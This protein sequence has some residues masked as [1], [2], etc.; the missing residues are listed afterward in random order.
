MRSTARSLG[1]V[2]DLL[3]VAAPEL[4]AARLVSLC[5]I[6]IGLLLQEKATPG[7]P[8]AD[9]WTLF[10]GYPFAQK[11]GAVDATG[12]RT[13]RTARHTLWTWGR[14]LAWHEALTEY[15]RLDRQ[16]R[17]YEIADPA[18]PAVRRPSLSVAPDR[19]DAYERLLDVAP[20]FAG[21][22]MAFATAGRHAFPVGRHLATVQL[23]PCALP[24]PSGHDLAAPAVNGG[25]QLSFRWDK[26]LRTAAFMDLVQHANWTGRLAAIRLSTCRGP[27]FRRARHFKV[28]RIQHLLGIV[29]AGKSTLRDVLV[30]HLARRGL[31]TTVVVGDV[32]EQLKLVQLYNTFVPGSAAPVLGA[33]GRQQHAERLHRRLIGRGG[34]NLLAHDDPGFAYL[35][36]SCAL[37]A[38]RHEGGALADDLLAFGEAPCTRLQPRGRR[39]DDTDDMWMQYPVACPFWSGCPRHH[40]ARELVGAAV[41]V[42]TPASLVDSGVPHPQNPERIRYL[43]L[44]C[45]RSDLVIVDEADRVQ[46]QLDRMF[47]PAIPLI[48]GGPG[49]RSFLDDVNQHRIRELAGAGRIQ[50]SDRDVENWSAAV[51]TTQAAADRLVAM[52]VRDRHLRDWV[53][54]GYFSAWT[55][56]LRLLEERYPLPEDDDT[57]AAV[58]APG[59]EH[60]HRA[61]RR[62]LTETLDAFRENPFGDR[63]PPTGEGT[64]LT[65]LMGELLHTTYPARTRTR[66]DE[67][68]RRLFDLDP[69]LAPTAEGRERYQELRGQAIRKQT[70]PPGQAEAG[71]RR[72]GRRRKTGLP[73]DPDTWCRLLMSRFEFTLLLS[74]LEPKLALINA[75]WPRVAAALNLGFNEMYRRPLDYGPMVP[76]APMGNVIGFQFLMDGPDRGGV[77][78]GEL[79][80]F[81]CSGVGRELLRVMPDLPTVDGRPGTNVLLMS[82]SSWA[83]KSSRYHVPV[84]I[85]VL[86]EPA[87]DE[88]MR[89]AEQSEFRFEFLRDGCGCRARC[90][91]PEPNQAQR[92]SGEPLDRRADVLRRMTIALARDDTG[93]SRLQEELRMLPE[94][95]R[96]ILLLVG[97][98][99]EAKVVADTLHT[100][101]NRWKGRVLRLVSDDDPDAGTWAEDE[102]HH[103]PVL[104]RGDVE[105]LAATRADILVAPLLAVERGHNIL[106]LDR[107]HAAI[108][109]IYFLARPNPRPDDLGL[110]VHAI[111]DWIVR[112]ID[113]GEFADWVRAEATLGLG[114]RKVRDL[115][116]S[117]W[118]RV[119]ARS[120]AWSRL[121]DDRVQVT[122]DLLVLIWQV[123]GRS[124]RGAVP[125]RV[126][127]VD[128]AFSPHLA[129]ESSTGDPDTEKTSL[130]HSIHAVLAPYFT[131]GSSVPAT[132]RRIVQ[133]LYRPM[134]AALDRCL[135]LPVEEKSPSCTD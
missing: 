79:R 116:R 48:G 42:A 122:W 85:G 10:S 78:T 101:N 62:E 54:T 108:G 57:P 128:A 58:P 40:G 91:C 92:L 39:G 106:D 38:L 129:A 110:A 50:L 25:R 53:R 47:A 112:A 114:A 49:T 86:I 76:E 45:R 32:A 96:H 43:E 61:P 7:E 94:S 71:R 16:V 34:R 51:N 89:I 27:R 30:V 95:R 52:L 80:F 69:L 13:L 77:R 9:A 36:T 81:R 125:T 102:E 118:Y 117:Q 100:L 11:W 74:A 12:Q 14:R 28:A 46:M 18:R 63:R 119:L 121:G 29:G 131:S 104:R 8:A 115:A 41:W 17:G 134:W 64:E 1:E 99:E 124:V 5:E 37:N 24:P 67:A 120:M 111:N 126:A 82:G 56:Q 33:S 127:F 75:M 133:A 132:D 88:L 105:T 35:S 55:L 90:V 60:P 15:Q 98:Y 3:S 72:S 20:A 83:G 4:K 130:L 21:R 87:S 97:S 109:S 23:P 93:I 68:L 26:L 2:V 19:W 113:G 31:R 66:L 73:E 135:P 22:P 84:P 70:R 107:R 65:V 59:T 6:E 103:A 44:A 123:I